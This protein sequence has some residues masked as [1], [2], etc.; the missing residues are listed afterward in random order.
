[1][2]CKVTSYCFNISVN[3][4]KGTDPLVTWVKLASMSDISLP[5]QNKSFK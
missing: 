1:M 3:I 4:I 5:Y 2:F